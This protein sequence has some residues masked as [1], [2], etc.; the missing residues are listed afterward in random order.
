[1][2]KLLWIALLP[3]AGCASTLVTQA[4]DYKTWEAQDIAAAQNGSVKWSDHYQQAYDRLA[5]L[6]PIQGKADLMRDQSLMLIYSQGYERGTITPEEFAAYQREMGARSAERQAQGAQAQSDAHRQAAGTFANS[7]QNI[8]N[9]NANF[10]QQRAIAAPPAPYV[11]MNPAPT[12]CLTQPSGN[13]LLTTC[14]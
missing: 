3:L 10:Y 2:R 1:M 14:R 12:N 6:P 7:L 8:A 11:N 5:T 9:Q 4:R 13:G